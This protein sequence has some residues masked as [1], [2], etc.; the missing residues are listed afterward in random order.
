MSEQN[1]RPVEIGLNAAIVAMLGR[2]PA[3]LRSTS[4]HRHGPDALPYGRFDPQAHRTM[5]AGLRELVEA[6][7]G[8]NPGYVEQ[9]Y[10]FGDRGRYPVEGD[11]SPHAVSVG[12][13]ALTRIRDVA[14]GEAS[15]EP[16]KWRG[17]YQYLPWEDWRQ[18]RPA[19]LDQTIIPLLVEWAAD[20]ARTKPPV[21]GLDTQDRVKIAFGLE[22]LEW[23]D[24]LVLDRYEL[25]YSGGLVD[26]AVADGRRERPRTGVQLGVAMLHDHRRILATAIARLRSKLKYRPVIFELMAKSFTLTELQQTVESIF[27]RP[28]HKQNFRRL[29][30][31]AGLVE[32]TGCHP[33]HHRRAARSALSFPPGGVEG[34]PC[35]RIAGWPELGQVNRRRLPQSEYTYHFHSRHLRACPSQA[36]R[37]RGRQTQ[38]SIPPPVRLVDRV[39]VWNVE[40][41]GSPPQGRG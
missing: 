5:E 19:L 26:E 9:L 12:Y 14:E 4:E 34:T 2:E 32:P 3:I 23:D 24:E 13:L 29:V 10:T 33:A 35:P 8:F 11:R 39:F 18:G 1:A 40:R 38:E 37:R 17:C 25:M 21:R 31:T 27:G 20:A 7:T 6:Q 28:I 16:D 15:P 41:C 22:G 36:K 30:E